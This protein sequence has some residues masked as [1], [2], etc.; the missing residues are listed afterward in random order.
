MNKIMVIYQCQISGGTDKLLIHLI[1][2]WPNKTTR[3]LIFLHHQNSGNELIINQLRDSNVTTIIYNIGNYDYKISNNI[4]LNLIK[5][6]FVKIKRLI[7]AVTLFMYF[8]T[9]LMKHSPDLLYLHNGGYIGSF[10]LH[11]A[12]LAVKRFKNIKSIMGIQNLPALTGCGPVSRLFNYISNS[13]IDAYILGNNRTK[14]VFELKTKLDK[15]KLFAIDEGVN[16]NQQKK[17]QIKHSQNI[18][19]AMIGTY[20]ERKGHAILLKALDALSV[21]KSKNKININF[22]GQSKFGNIFKI[23]EL[24]NNLELSHLINYHEYEEDIDKLYLQ[25]DI[26]V[27]PSL[28]SETMPLVLIDA[29]A[30]YK[31]IIGSKLQGVMDLIEHGVNGF[32]FDIGDYNALAIYL[33]K[34][35]LNEELRVSFGSAGRNRYESRFT[36]ERM[37]NDYH[38]VFIKTINE[39]KN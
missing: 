24:G 5:R 9:N 32:L 19:I 26:I 16:V 35:I 38:D 30:Y 13:T 17:R 21:T 7:S 3:W 23:K 10:D 12:G 28:D 20:E 22:F 37:A 11:I 39:V 1:N 36:A 27:L 34:L 33:E 8:K 18:N 6:Y 29:M 25:Q 4:Y 14:K 31:P 2:D 15:E